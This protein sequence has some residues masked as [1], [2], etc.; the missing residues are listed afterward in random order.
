M[1]LNSV[2]FGFKVLENKPES[3]YNP[4]LYV[5]DDVLS[6]LFLLFD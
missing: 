3:S 1:S 5:I 6:W 4:L 2:W